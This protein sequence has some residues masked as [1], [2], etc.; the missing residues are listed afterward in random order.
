MHKGVLHSTTTSPCKPLFEKSNL[1]GDD[2]WDTE[3]KT[4]DAQNLNGIERNRKQTI[5]KNDDSE[6]DLFVPIFSIVSLMLL[7]GTYGYETLRL[8]NE[9]ELYSPWR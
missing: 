8:Y 5:T 7:F 2:G 4:R 6:R 3:T 1:D 9:G